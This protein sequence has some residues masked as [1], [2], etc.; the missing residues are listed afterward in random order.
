M[1]KQTLANLLQTFYDMNVFVDKN[2]SYNQIKQQSPGI[3]I[4]TV[5][6]SDIQRFN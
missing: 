2:C 3:I 6:V 4:S 1:C 5:D